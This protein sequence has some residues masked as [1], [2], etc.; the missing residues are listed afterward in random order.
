M[1]MVVCGPTVV[2]VVSAA[3][4]PS[5][6]SSSSSP[7][8]PLNRMP[9]GTLIGPSVLSIVRVSLPPRPNTSIF[10]SELSGTVYSTSSVMS[11][12]TSRSEALVVLRRI[13]IT[14]SPAVPSIRSTLGSARN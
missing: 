2:V 4:C 14:S 7:A 9:S 11:N 1:A 10:C 13:S 12:A 3:P 5:R 6:I 8:P